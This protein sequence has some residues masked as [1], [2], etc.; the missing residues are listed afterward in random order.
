MAGVAFQKGDEIAAMDRERLARLQGRGV[1]AAL[2]AVDQRHFAQHLA[3]P[4]NREHG[5]LAFAG[6]YA[7]F[8][9]PAD[10]SQ[11]AVARLAA[12]ENHLPGGKTF[13]P[14]EGQHAFQLLGFELPKQ[15]MSRN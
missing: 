3:A 9:A 11:H 5:F 4:Q 15:Y 8:Y 1:G 14:G 12:A 6:R 13:G 2:L 10:H 7:N